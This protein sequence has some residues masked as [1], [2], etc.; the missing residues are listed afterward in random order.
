MLQEPGIGGLPVHATPVVVQLV[1][2][3]VGG[4]EAEE[5]HAVVHEIHPLEL[6]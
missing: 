3:R 1:G 2:H 5:Q 4:L 6:R